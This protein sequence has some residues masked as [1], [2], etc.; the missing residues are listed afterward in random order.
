MFKLCLRWS[1]SPHAVGAARLPALADKLRA[2]A[3]GASPTVEE[4]QLPDLPAGARSGDFV[5][6]VRGMPA[7]HEAPASSGTPPQLGKQLAELRAHFARGAAAE[8]SGRASGTDEAQRHYSAAL[9]L[10]TGAAAG[11]IGAAGATAALETARQFDHVLLRLSLRHVRH[12]QPA[13]EAAPATAQRGRYAFETCALEHALRQLRFANP[14]LRRVRAV[15]HRHATT[16]RGGGLATFSARDAAVLGLAARELEAVGQKYVYSCTT[17]KQRS[18]A[19][20]GHVDHC[21]SNGLVDK[22]G[23]SPYAPHL[24]SI[25]LD[26]GFHLGSPYTGMYYTNPESDRD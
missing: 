25:R 4:D 11:A 22:F 9:D 17:Y 24:T 23:T 7:I 14:K 26:F 10:G 8:R 1:A 15:L 19:F 16:G 5:V 13:I 20:D 21:A 12:T 3:A 18:K 6:P 2:F